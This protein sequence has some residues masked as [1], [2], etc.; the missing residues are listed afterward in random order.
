MVEIVGFLNLHVMNLKEILNRTTHILLIS[1]ILVC[2]NFAANLKNFTE[3][4]MII[5]KYF[6]LPFQCFNFFSFA[7]FR[8]GRWGEILEQ[9][10]FKRGWKDSDVED[11][12][13]VI[14]SFKPVF[15]FNK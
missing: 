1:S 9:G 7:N 12:S 6:L 4:L 2:L 8:W 13:R 11:C 10:S 3:F 5:L 14:V 15:T